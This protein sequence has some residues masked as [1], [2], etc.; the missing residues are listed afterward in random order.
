MS[1]SSV[2][3][4]CAK[5]TGTKSWRQFSAESSTATCRPKVGEDAPDI[6]GNVE[7]AAA[8]DADELVLR[9][10]RRSGNA[11]RGPCRPWPT[12]MVVLDEFD[13]D[14][15]LRR[16]AAGCRPPRRSRGRRRTLRS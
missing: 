5:P 16:S 2:Q 3:K 11:G 9:E 1:G 4:P 10:G 15:R 13:D 12:G 7:D 14:A 6:D 8:R